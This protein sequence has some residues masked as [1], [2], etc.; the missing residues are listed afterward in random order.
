MTLDDLLAR[1]SITELVLGRLHCL[2][3]KDWD[4]Y[5]GFHTTDVV[6]RTTEGTWSMEDRLWWEHPGGVEQ[7]HGWG[8]YVETYRWE[9]T[10][11]VAARTL[12][13]T[14]V[15]RTDGYFDYLSTTG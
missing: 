14:R 11:L 8:H 1:A 2:D 15:E 13:R 4:R 5:G 6:S 12:H 9:G 10:W 3:T 7:L